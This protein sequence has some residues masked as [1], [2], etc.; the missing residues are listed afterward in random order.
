METIVRERSE[1]ELVLNDSASLKAD[2]ARMIAEES[3]RVAR[4][5]SRV[6]RLHGEDVSNIA[7]PTYTE[8]EVLGD[9]YPG[10]PLA[11]PP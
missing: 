7:P 5:T 9:W 3:S 11:P 1:I 2:V 4:L 10:D 8:E 6:L